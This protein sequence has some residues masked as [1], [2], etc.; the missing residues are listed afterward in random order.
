MTIR[1]ILFSYYFNKSIM[2]FYETN[3]EIDHVPLVVVN[4]RPYI[5]CIQ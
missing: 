3:I 1:I 2:H 5:E 4:T